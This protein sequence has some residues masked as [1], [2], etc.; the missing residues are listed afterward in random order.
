MACWRIVAVRYVFVCCWKH[1][2]TWVFWGMGLMVICRRVGKFRYGE[3]LWI[4]T[5]GPLESVSGRHVVGV[6]EMPYWPVDHGRVGCR[7][8]CWNF[9]QCNIFWASLL[10]W[11]WCS[12]DF[13]KSSWCLNGFDVSSPSW[14][15][16]LSVVLMDCSSYFCLFMKVQRQGIY[17][18]LALWQVDFLSGD[19]RRTIANCGFRW[20]GIAFICMTA[21]RLRTGPI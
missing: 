13:W 12:L 20:P 4:P 15:R 1:V 19:L 6:R 11:Q 9:L 16:V 18:L 21:S 3:G 5:E 17:L 14:C 2:D 8:Q 7:F 10:V